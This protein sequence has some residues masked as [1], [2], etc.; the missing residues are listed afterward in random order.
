M[1]SPFL[2]AL[3]E[4]QEVLVGQFRTS[5]PVEVKEQDVDILLSSAPGEIQGSVTLN[6]GGRNVD[7]SALSI[8]IRPIFFERGGGYGVWR[9][10]SAR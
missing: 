1:G 6:P 3:L 8:E 5:Q 2:V 4:E 10:P 7:L 9:P